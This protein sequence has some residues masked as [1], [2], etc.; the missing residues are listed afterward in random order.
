MFGY[1]SFTGTSICQNPLVNA[2]TPCHIISPADFTVSHITIHTV[3]I[4]PPTFVALTF[5]VKFWFGL[6]GSV[7]F[8]IC[9]YTFVGY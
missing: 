2:M 1:E 5:I 6:I 4:L 9:V 7:L 3:F 8:T